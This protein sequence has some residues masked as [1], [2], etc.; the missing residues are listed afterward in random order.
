MKLK[1]VAA[2][3]KL[4]AQKLSARQGDEMKQVLSE[5]KQ[6]MILKKL[7]NSFLLQKII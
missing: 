5:P 2:K 6:E 1:Y 4:A 3:N 7:S